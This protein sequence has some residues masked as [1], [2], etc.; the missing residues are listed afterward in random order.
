MPYL[1]GLVLIMWGIP[2]HFYISL[3]YPRPLC[4]GIH[5]QQ[6]NGCGWYQR[7]LRKQK[8]LAPAAFLTTIHSGR[9][10]LSYIVAGDKTCYYI[11]SLPP[12]DSLIFGLMP[13]QEKF[14]PNWTWQYLF[15]HGAECWSKCC[16]NLTVEQNRIHGTSG[17]PWNH[18]T[19]LQNARWLGV[20]H[21][22]CW[23]GNTH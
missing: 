2:R 16:E 9:R 14:S 6:E 23:Q 11:W 8:V 17:F 5:S 3:K 4:L 10:K 22:L 15:R 18:G 20:M 7:L 19:V 1:K 12:A 21:F 13:K